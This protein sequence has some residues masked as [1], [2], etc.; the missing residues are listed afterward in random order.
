[1]GGGACGGC[2]RGRGAFADREPPRRVR[3]A[4]PRGPAARRLRDAAAVDLRPHARRRPRARAVPGGVALVGDGLGR[5]LDRRAARDLSAG[6]RGAAA[7]LARGAAARLLRDVRA[8]RGLPPGARLPR[9]PAGPRHRAARA[10]ARGRVDRDRLAG[11]DGERGAEWP[12]RRGGGARGRRA[13]AGGRVRQADTEWL[14]QARGALARGRDQLLSR[15]HAAGRWKAELETHPTMDAHDLPMREVLGIRPREETALAA[16]WVRSRQQ[17]AGGFATFHGGPSDLSTTIEAYAALR[18]AGDP[19]EAEH[20]KR[21]RELVLGLGGI[22]AS[23]VFT[24][25]WLALFGEWSWREL[26]ALP[27]ELILLP[28]WFPLNVYDFACW[29]RQTIVP[30]TVVAAHPPVR[31]LPFSLP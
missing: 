5:P 11:H 7:A 31:P 9:A 15:P 20:M 17:G 6:F 10:L 26:P 30:L 18:L 12:Q 22:E 29:A 3:R 27:P 21:A 1:G 4:R 24:R 13:R 8:G 16:N 14:A 28:A 19:P 23:R 25:M 2:V